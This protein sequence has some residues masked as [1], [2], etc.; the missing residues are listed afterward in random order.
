MKTERYRIDERDN[1]P[2][3]VHVYYSE[4]HKHN[5]AR[6]VHRAL[7]KR[8]RKLSYL[9]SLELPDNRDFW[10]A[11]RALNIKQTPLPDGDYL[12]EMIEPVKKTRPIKFKTL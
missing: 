3:G 6:A 5:R 9:L 1:Q 11:A 8:P 10:W 7:E 12:W 4:L 2:A